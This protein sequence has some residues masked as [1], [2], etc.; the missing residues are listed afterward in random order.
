MRPNG[1]IDFKSQGTR[2]KEWTLSVYD[3]IHCV[4]RF[5]C[6]QPWVRVRSIFTVSHS[7][8][9]TIANKCMKPTA[10]GY[11]YSRF[12]YPEIVLKIQKFNDQKG[13]DT[14][15]PFWP[16]DDPKV[17]YSAQQENRASSKVQTQEE[18]YICK[19]LVQQF[20]DQECPGNSTGTEQWEIEK[21]REITTLWKN[22]F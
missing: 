18:I 14:F 8:L 6:S 17:H 16:W 1:Y 12:S 9:K 13:C 4:K 20:L 10:N 21:C 19:V 15:R 2:W 3:M 5:G 7:H 22:I 11:K